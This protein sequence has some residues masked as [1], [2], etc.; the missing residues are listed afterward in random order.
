MGE[1]FTHYQRRFHLITNP[2]YSGG[3]YHRCRH[4][5][6]HNMI[7]AS[8]AAGADLAKTLP[9]HRNGADQ[10]ATNRYNGIVRKVNNLHGKCDDCPCQHRGTHHERRAASTP[11]AL[12]AATV[13]PRKAR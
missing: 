6:D 1:P 7:C 10:A 12:V 13:I 3:K 8:C 4:R 9:A 2:S 11:V 5:K